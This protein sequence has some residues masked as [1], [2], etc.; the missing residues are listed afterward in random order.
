MKRAL[1]L[2]AG[3][4]TALPINVAMAHVPEGVDFTP[5]PRTTTKAAVDKSD[6]VE[7]LAKFAFPNKE[8][9]YFAGG[10]DLDFQGKYVYAMQQ[11]QNGG[12]H[13]LDH[14]GKKPRKVGFFACPG[15]QNDV[16]VV[17]P[18]LIA[19]GYHN[20]QCGEPGS[21]VR[22]VDVR[23]P[24]RPKLLGA[25]NDLPGGTHTLTV[26]PGK[27]IIYASPGGLANGG[28]V[29][30]ILDVS[31]PN[32][33]EV[34]ATFRPNPTGCHDL[35]FY[36]TKET[37]I[38]ACAGLG[39]TQIW[40][41]SDPLAPRTIGHIVNPFT[42]FDHSV[43]FTDDG[44]YMVLGDENFAAHECSGGPTGAV[45]I[46]DV[47]TPQLPV[48]VGYY[49]ID[50][51]PAV[52]TTVAPGRPNWCTAHLFNFIPGT[53]TLVSSWYAS[54]M[55]VIDFSNPRNP[56]EI[57]H[58]MEDGGTSNYWSAYWYDGRIYANDRVD[59]VDVFEVKGLKEK[60]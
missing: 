4:M 35:A 23:N 31:N 47:S 3:V 33:P 32:K 60:R 19:L 45:H 54:G 44:K 48:Q 16:A 9:D 39:E 50:R 37:Q 28:G 25:V 43:A 59:G 53:Y 42:F 6:N 21:G 36:V 38:A 11:G 56:T 27:D 46:Y 2:L 7:L 24:R 12:I 5:A 51:G 57:A 55:N 10:T 14:S 41:V 20:S 40:D 34:A 22:L 29:E 15:G 8:G 1:L 30:Q 58:Y 49:G 52:W 18:G 13:I 17:K 26:Y